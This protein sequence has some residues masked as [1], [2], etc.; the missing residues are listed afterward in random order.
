MDHLEIRDQG[1]P[2]LYIFIDESGDFNFSVS[3]TKFYTITAAVTPCPWEGADDITRLK[4]QILSLSLFPDLPKEYL[5]KKLA[6]RF[7]ACEDKQRVRDVFFNEIQVINHFRAFS[8]VIRKRR[9]H[10]SLQ[11]PNK[12]YSRFLG[13]LLDYIFKR[14]RYPFLAIF[15][16]GTPV[17]KQRDAFIN[18]VK[19]EI[20]TK[21]SRKPYSIYFPTSESNHFLQ[22]VDYINWAIFKKWERDDRRS[23]DLISSCLGA[24]ELDIFRRGDTEFY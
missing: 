16:A 21:G 15:L 14:Y 6:L 23:Y 22:I 7:H 1:S 13:Y 18:S 12:F 8:I 9:T 5:D 4:H 3:G 19:T 17:N 10:P 24:P 2:P 11:E 20:N